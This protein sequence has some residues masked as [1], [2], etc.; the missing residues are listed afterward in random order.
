MRKSK[1]KGFE[2]FCELPV[3]VPKECVPLLNKLKEKISG[4]SRDNQRAKGYI[5]QTALK[6]MDQQTPYG[7]YWGEWGR[8]VHCDPPEKGQDGYFALHLVPPRSPQE[9]GV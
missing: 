9:K 4:S 3:Q 7:F 6:L 8:L 1:R 5:I 2:N